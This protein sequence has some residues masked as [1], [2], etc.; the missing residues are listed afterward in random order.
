MNKLTN[1]KI[2][3]QTVDLSELYSD[4]VPEDKVHVQ[5]GWGH[6]AYAQAELD[7][8]ERVVG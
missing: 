1:G 6:S 2:S 8:Q 5:L 7:R 4:M 3:K